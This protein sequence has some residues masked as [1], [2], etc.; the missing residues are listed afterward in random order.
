VAKRVGVEFLVVYIQN[1]TYSSEKH[2]DNL[3]IPKQIIATI[4]QMNSKWKFQVK[5]LKEQ[6]N[7]ELSVIVIDLPSATQ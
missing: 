4:T 1:D 6:G 2:K 5:R 3:F 7:S